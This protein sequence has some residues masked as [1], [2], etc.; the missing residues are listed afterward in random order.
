MDG[1][2]EVSALAARFLTYVFWKLADFSVMLNS[3]IMQT[4]KKRESWCQVG[5]MVTTCSS[6]T[7]AD[8]RRTAWRYIL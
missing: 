6:E 4:R 3:S 7:L 8:F 1:E 2:D 5:K